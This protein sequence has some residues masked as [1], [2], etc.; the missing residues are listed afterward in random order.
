MP[1]PARDGF[2]RFDWAACSF[3]S[4][5]IDGVEVARVKLDDRYRPTAYLAVVPAGR[6]T[7]IEYLEVDSNLRGQGDIGPAILAALRERLPD[8]TLA[9]YPTVES[10]RWWDRRVREGTWIRVDHPEGPVRGLPL[11]LSRG[12]GCVTPW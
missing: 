2:S 4:A 7:L 9:A 3:T 10:Q 1:F 11:Y 6:F 12:E 8:R 5:L